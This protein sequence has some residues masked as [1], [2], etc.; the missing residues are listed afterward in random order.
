MAPYSGSNP[1]NAVVI[2]DSPALKR[3][4]ISGGGYQSTNNFTGYHSEADSGDDLFDGISTPPAA[5]HLTQPTQILVR[6]EI[7]SSPSTNKVVEVQV[8]A[9]SPFRPQP[10]AAV[11]P[12]LPS[13]NRGRLASLMAPAGTTFRAP[14][15]VKNSPL[16]KPTIIDISDDDGPQYKGDSSEDD[17]FSRRNL[18]PSAFKS[19]HSTASPEGSRHNMGNP[20]GASSTASVL[21]KDIIAS[22]AYKPGEKSR[23]Q[24]RPERAMPV[25]QD[26]ALDDEENLEMR[27]KINRIRTV[28]PHGFTML[29][30]RNALL[31]KKGDVDDACQLL[32][33]QSS[34]EIS[35]DEI[36]AGDIQQDLRQQPQMKRQLQ[37]PIKSI[38]ERYS[39]TQ[40]Q[41]KAPISPRVGTPPAKPK[42]RLVKGRRNPSSP[43]VT[44]D[45]PKPPTPAVVHSDFDSD[46]SGLGSET[47]E[48][49]ELDG[50]VLN[51]LNKCQINELAD[52]ASIKEEVA[53][54]MLAQRPFKSLDA[55]RRVSDAKPTKTGRKSTKA[56]I[57][58]K[59]V[60]VAINMWSGYEAVD[61][62]V[63]KCEQL[64]R[65]LAKEM[66][67]WGFDVFGASKQGELELVTLEDDDETL[68]DS[69]IGTPNS[70]AAS[71]NG[72]IGDEEVKAA[73]PKNRP[74]SFLKKPSIMN[75]DITLKDY[76]LVG[77]NWLALLYKFK[78]SC[79]L[80]DD[81]G[82]GKTCQVIAF[83]SHLAEIGQSGPHLV[84]VPP[85]TLENWLREFAHFSSGLVVEP[86][87]GWF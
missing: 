27:R 54:T 59:I 66:A 22:S 28:F 65:P 39:S 8:P 69:G 52:L 29:M 7:L 58:E 2:P 68:R 43:A 50:R 82:L 26:M 23:A 13:Q 45:S 81:M 17:D 44:I 64:G 30:I 83:L 4:K 20:D 34:I 9:S 56:P 78:L 60:Q 85:S 61:A 57:G 33:A 84:I 25:G 21:F 35:D 72:D 31:E 73:A 37:A 51:F 86:Y 42:R 3:Q 19:G 63:A 49:P 87:Y 16:K 55:A 79:I 32:I 71:P 36:E 6:P 53:S 77:L 75:D 38:Q 40:H 67:K 14:L 46:D 12:T 18:K 1:S 70:K 62:L 10:P 11:R 15:G 48:D 24:N 80:A 74:I 41:K 47:E 5:K 76:Q